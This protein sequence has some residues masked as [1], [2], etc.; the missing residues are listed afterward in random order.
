MT[1]IK[2]L[3]NGFEQ[4]ISA[5]KKDGDLGFDLK[6]EKATI[7]GL[8]M[9]YDND[10]FEEKEINLAEYI[11]DPSFYVFKRI[12]YIQYD[13]CIQ[14]KSPFGSFI[15]P[16]SSLSKYNLL[17]CNSV[18]VID[19]GYTGNLILRFQY[20]FQPED[21]VNINAYKIN[22]DKVYKE[23]DFVGQ[24]IFSPFGEKPNLEY[25]ETLEKTERSDGGFGSTD[26]PIGDKIY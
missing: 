12:D 9:A 5:P 13:T 26:K 15:Y 11:L 17:L 24:I 21:F 7:K 10:V 6:A 23:G 16:R 25:T 18:G 4:N 3:K 19:V 22:T 14:L 20:Q 2:I 8:I 1:K